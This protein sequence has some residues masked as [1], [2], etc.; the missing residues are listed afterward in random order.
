MKLSAFLLFILSLVLA[1]LAL[2][3]SD[4]EALAAALA[5]QGKI[6]ALSAIQ[7]PSLSNFQQVQGE[8]KELPPFFSR[9]GAALSGLD[10]GPASEI[11]SASLDVNVKVETLQGMTIS[12]LGLF[13]E[14][15]QGLDA[16]LDQIQ[17]LLPSLIQLLKARMEAQTP[18]LASLLATAVPLPLLPGFLQPTATPVLSTVNVPSGPQVIQNNIPPPPG[19]PGS[20]NPDTSV[21]PGGPQVPTYAPTAAATQI[22]PVAQPTVAGARYRAPVA[23]VVLNN[24][25]KA[26]VANTFEGTV[27]VFDSSAKR[28]TKILPVGGE[29][30]ALA[31]NNSGQQL[32]VAN[33]GTNDITLINTKD[34]SVVERFEVGR[35]PVDIVFSNDGK[36]AYSVNQGSGTVSVIDVPHLTVSRT[37][38]VGLAPSR[39]AF[40]AN[41]KY[42]YVTLTREDSVAIIDTQSDNVLGV[43]KE[44]LP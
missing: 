30:W 22:Q 42:L 14:T 10:L 11:R 39:A 17:T 19:Q 38:K 5:A 4:S 13:I 29:P 41:G 18:A 40:S 12:N 43:A 26:Y 16:R 33:A 6:A 21:I 3:A 44:D 31:L 23:I 7:S 32:L 35:R 20:S 15:A 24:G 1:P 25:S 27:G 37:I 28:F 34:D 36:K 9:L 8:A 2:R